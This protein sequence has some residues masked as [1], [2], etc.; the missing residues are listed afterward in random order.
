MNDISNIILKSGINSLIYE[1]EEG[2]K[3]SL[4][5]SLSFKLNEALEG[6]HNTFASE[7]MYENQNTEINEDI[8][9]LI[10]FFENY[11]PKSNNTLNLK[12]NTSIN[13]QEQQVNNLKILFNSLNPK[14]RELMAKNILENGKGLKMNL[15]FY[16]SAKKVIK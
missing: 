6:V 8:K 1:S 14:N 15:E 12:N 11:D 13:I 10:K 4:I 2:F 3:K 9:I 5:N 16:E 7:L